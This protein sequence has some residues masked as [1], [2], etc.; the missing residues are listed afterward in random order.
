MRTQNNRGM[1]N[2]CFIIMGEASCAMQ[3]VKVSACVSSVGEGV[4]R[5]RTSLQ[6][7]FRSCTVISE[8]HRLLALRVPA[9]CRNYFLIAVTAPE[10]CRGL[11]ATPGWQ[12]APPQTQDERNVARIFQVR[13][14]SCHSERKPRKL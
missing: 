7:L 5:S 3:T 1:T 11:P 6:R 9:V 14:L 2:R 8:E 12:P 4:P 10:C 13:P